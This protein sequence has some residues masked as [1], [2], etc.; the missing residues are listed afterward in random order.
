MNPFLLDEVRNDVIDSLP[1]EFPISQYT[2][3]CLRDP[4]QTFG[5]PAMIGR[6]IAEPRGRGGIAD[7]QP[8]NTMSSSG[9]WQA[10][11]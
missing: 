6:E 7:L 2:L 11:G 8:L 1:Q 4:A 9:W 5:A 3:D 10:S